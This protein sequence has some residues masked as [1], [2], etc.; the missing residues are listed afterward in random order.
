MRVDL[1][2]CTACVTVYPNLSGLIRRLFYDAVSNADRL[3]RKDQKMIM[4][5][6]TV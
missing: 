3:H 5:G 1:K 2:N 4:I 6:V